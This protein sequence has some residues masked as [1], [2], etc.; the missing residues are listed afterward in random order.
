MKLL[1]DKGSTSQILDVFI[2][3]SFSYSGLTGLSCSSASL[4]CYYHRNT[5]VSATAITLVDMTVGTYISGGFMQ[6]DSTNLP[7]FYQLCVPNAA[8]QTGADSFSLLL[9]GAA[10]M[11]PCPL[12]IQLK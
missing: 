5:A 10:S 4:S 11:A 3:D 1:L 6:I 8:F 12:E 7:G 9:K 2:Q